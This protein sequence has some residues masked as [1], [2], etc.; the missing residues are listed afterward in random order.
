MI[1][2]KIYIK[3]LDEGTKVLRPVPAIALGNNIYEVRGEELYDPEDEIWE[4]IPGAHVI[5]EEQ[6]LNEGLVLVAVREIAK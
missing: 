5:V 6:K 1:N 4:F 2:G 3:L